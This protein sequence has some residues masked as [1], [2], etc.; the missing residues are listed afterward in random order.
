MPD[1]SDGQTHAGIII[2][3]VLAVFVFAVLRY[4]VFGY[5]L[6]AVGEKAAPRPNMA[7]LPRGA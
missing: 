1:I 5:R 6:D 7:A 2:A 3:V 4:S